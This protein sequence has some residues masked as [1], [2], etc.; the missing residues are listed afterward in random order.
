M[1]EE[2]LLEVDAV[3]LQE[4]AVADEVVLAVVVCFK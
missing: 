3:A 2:V 4:V 1:A